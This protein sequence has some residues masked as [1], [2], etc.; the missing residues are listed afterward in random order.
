MHVASTH[1]E[2]DRHLAAWRQAGDPIVPNTIALVPTM[3]SLHE[4]H[5]SLVHRAGELADRVVVSIF[6]NPTQFN[7]ARDFDTYPRDLERDRRLLEEVGCDLL[8]APTED[9][10]YPPG[11]STFIEV[12]GVSEGLEGEFRPGHFRGVATVVTRL[13]RLVRPHLAVFGEK[14][15]QQLAIVRRLT[16]DLDLE[17]E[18][19]AHPTVREDDGLAMSSR[20]RRLSTEE[21]RAA[22]V[23]HQ[24]LARAANLIAAGET[25][26]DEVR[27][28]MRDTVEEESLARFEYAEVVDPDTFRPLERI[29]DRVLL[30]VAGWVGD[31]RLIDNLT[32]TP[33]ALGAARSVRLP[34]EVLA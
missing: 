5:L 19:V 1:E 25:D 9:V 17:V 13:F 21:R 11:F 12:D 4:G 2:L 7:E 10:I 32:V 22:L 28:L 18:I 20:N 34:E 14:D 29:E 31:T 16:R 6:V 8:F 3:G 30:P 24:A 33:G 23:F 15:A 26:V 27:T